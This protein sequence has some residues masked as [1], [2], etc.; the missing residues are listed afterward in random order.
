MPEPFAPNPVVRLPL[1]DLVEKDG[2]NRA[3]FARGVL[4]RVS[5]LRRSGFLRGESAARR[6]CRA[7]WA[8]FPVFLAL[9]RGE[10]DER[11]DLGTDIRVANSREIAQ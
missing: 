4:V 1:V 5:P 2:L 6:P 7:I 8:L 9:A 10:R 11:Q 3:G